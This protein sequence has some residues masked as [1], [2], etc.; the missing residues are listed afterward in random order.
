MIA[1]ARTLRRA[2]ESLPSDLMISGIHR[3]FRFVS[4]LLLLSAAPWSVRAGETAFKVKAQLVWGTDLKHSSS[5]EHK[6][7]DA[8]TAAEL[9]KIFKWENYFVINTIDAKVEKSDMQRLKM[10]EQC[11]IEIRALDDDRVE[12]ILYGEGKRVCRGIQK[13][14]A[15]EQC[16]IGGPAENESSWLVILRR[17]DKH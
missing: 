13:L 12:V 4:V 14:P 6:P 8:H 3:S 7:I 2:N 11:E 9:K 10:S 1:R 17:T 16:F 5:K 15:G